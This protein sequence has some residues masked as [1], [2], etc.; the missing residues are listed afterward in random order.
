MAVEPIDFDRL[1]SARDDG[2]IPLIR[3]TVAAFVG[4]TAAGPVNEPIRVRSIAEF[5]RVFGGHCSF[6]YV[7]HAVQ[8]YFQHGGHEAVVVRVTNRATRGE[9]EIPAGAGEQALKLQAAEPGADVCLRASVDHERVETQRD[10]FNLVVQQV[11]GRGSELI[12]DQEIFSAVSMNPADPRFV[13][14][15]LEESKLVRL[16]GPVPGLRPRATEARHPG[17]PL[18]YVPMSRNG[19]DGDALTDYDII[20]SNEEGTG[21]FA[22]ERAGR[23][24]LLCIPAAPGADVG[25][26]SFVAA[27]RYSRQRNA[28]LIWDPP[29]SWTSVADVV[30]GMRVTTR[31]GR[32][33]LTYFPRI[34]RRGD[35]FRNPVGLPAC[36]ALAGGIALADS[37]GVWDRDSAAD[38]VLKTSLTPVARV[39]G[40]GTSTLRRFGV[41]VLESVDG[42]GT[43][44]Q[45]RV[46]SA[47]AGAAGA[48]R[49]FHLRRLLLFVMSSAEEAG[50]L[51]LQRASGRRAR[52]RIASQLDDFLRALYARGAFTGSAPAQAF[53]VAPHGARVRF[54][55][56]MRQPGEFV[57]FE[58]E[59]GDA[60]ARLRPLP[61]VEAGQ[62]A[63]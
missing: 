17:A 12:R 40:R 41:N 58:L 39:G 6:S 7:S 37:C 22:L 44:I 43:R 8:H 45:P 63:S 11:V 27:E 4:R 5:Q 55:V 26:T 48:W 46:T 53:F 28:L 49:D 33:A 21:L 35:A 32:N 13:G 19:S 56:A 60:R 14:T 23:V 20:G 15:L 62:L 47:G 1:S 52:E 38:I 10:R 30:A 18:P 3:P 16:G 9:I 36:G 51:V 24:D 31:T 57:G 29:E 25:V 2:A 50:T 42:R 59:L 61:V 34:R 54:G